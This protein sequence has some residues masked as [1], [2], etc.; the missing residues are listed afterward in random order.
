MPATLPP[1]EGYDRAEGTVMVGYFFPALLK[2]APDQNVTLAAGKSPSGETT[3][4]FELDPALYLRFVRVTGDSVRSAAAD[5]TS[6]TGA[7][8]LRL[9][10]VWSPGEIRLHVAD[11][12]RPDRQV[13][14]RSGSA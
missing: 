7:S 2:D 12:D 6:L 11:T 8:K 5:A 3:L 1:S 14:G 4:R 9:M 10:G 13:T